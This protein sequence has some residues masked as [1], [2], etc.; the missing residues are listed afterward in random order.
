ML[1]FRLLL[2]LALATT[3]ASAADVSG[4]ARIVDGD[5]LDVAGQKIRIEGIDAFESGQSCFDAKGREWACGQAGTAYLLKLTR[6]QTVNCRGQD[7][8][9]YD[10]LIADCRASDINLGAAMVEQGLAL[11]FAKFSATYVDQE[12][13]ARKAG[14]GVWS[15][16]FLTPW[17][18]RS[19]MWTQSAQ[20]A[21][22]DCPIKGNI[23]D[24][25]KIYHTPY[26]DSYAKTRI[27]ESKGERWFCTESEALAAGWRTPLTN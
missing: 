1:T 13:Q 25:G 8:D 12:Q 14:T 16:T 10:R 19:K 26:S 9:P 7:Y 11:V 20:T 21:P 6:G 23:S 5:T 27:D 3:S 2:I 18:Y 4:R 22:G 17:E 24:N 15:G